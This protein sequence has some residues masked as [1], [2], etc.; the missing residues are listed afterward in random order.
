MFYLSCSVWP[1]IP[2]PLF[3]VTFEVPWFG[4]ATASPDI[5]IV[6]SAWLRFQTCHDCLRVITPFFQDCSRYSEKRHPACQRRIWKLCP[7]FLNPSAVMTYFLGLIFFFLHQSIQRTIQNNTLPTGLNKETQTLT[8][9]LSAWATRPFLNCI[10]MKAFLQY[11]LSPQYIFWTITK[12]KSGK[13]CATAL[14]MQSVNQLNFCRNLNLF[15]FFLFQM[16]ILVS[17]DLYTR[18]LIF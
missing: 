17:F 9:Q 6:C 1:Y 2:N 4:P 7:N 12:I 14:S 15:T 11:F 13:I 10:L 3:L 18:V 16:Q 5:C 8:W